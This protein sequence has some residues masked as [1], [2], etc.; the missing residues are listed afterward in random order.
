MFRASLMGMV[1]IACLIAGL[2]E[3]GGSARINPLIAPA[4]AS[5]SQIAGATAG[6]YVSLRVINAALSVAQETE[7][8][9]AFGAQA[10]VQPLRVLEPIDDTVERVADVVFAVAAG[11]ALMRVGLAPVAALGLVVLVL[12]LVLGLLMQS[13]CLVA[14][15]VAPMSSPARQAVRLGLALGVV[16]PVGF[17]LGVSLGEQMTQPQWDA[18]VAQLDAVTGEAAI[19]TGMSTQGLAEDLPPEMRDEGF[20][21]RLLGAVDAVARYRD[22]AGLFLNEADTIFGATL[23]IIGIFA[24]RMLVLPALLLWGAMTLLRRSVGAGG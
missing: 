9:A 23:T 22:A 16:L 21:G 1:A 20:M 5:A 12:V 10:S 14:P 7:V 3:L 2:V 18:A 15:K 8:G 19:L 11:A 17:A 6:V 24:L 4:E 13:V